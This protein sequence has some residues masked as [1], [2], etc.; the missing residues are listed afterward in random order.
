MNIAWDVFVCAWQC[1]NK[2]T[3]LLPIYMQANIAIV[4]L[5]L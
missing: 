2:A 3:W 4:K 1:P 5:D